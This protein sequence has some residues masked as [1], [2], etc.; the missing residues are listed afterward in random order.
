MEMSPQAHRESVI[1]RHAEPQKA[2]WHKALEQSAW[3]NSWLHWVPLGKLFNFS[4]PL[5]LFCKRKIISS[6]LKWL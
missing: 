6:Y 1:L 4:V 3:C 2:V 5:F